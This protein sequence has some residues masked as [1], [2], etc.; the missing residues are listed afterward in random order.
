MPDS[1]KLLKNYVKLFQVPTLSIEIINNNN[2]IKIN[3]INIFIIFIK[4]LLMLI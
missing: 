2:N 1:Q 3:L 4:K